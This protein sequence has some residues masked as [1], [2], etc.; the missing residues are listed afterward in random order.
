MWVPTKSEAVAALMVVVLLR[1]LPVKGVV[2][3]GVAPSRKVMAPLGISVESGAVNIEVKA[4]DWF[5]LAVVGDA[6][7]VRVVVAGTT[8][9][10]TVV[11]VLE[12]KAGL[13]LNVA[14]KV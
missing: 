7:R 11:E 14:V 10:M 6:A 1:G 13:P 5:W 12:A 3:K 2:A 9:W 8:T 4:T